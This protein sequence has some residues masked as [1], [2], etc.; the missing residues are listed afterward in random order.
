MS[1]KINYYDGVSIKGICK[2]RDHFYSISFLFMLKIILESHILVH[3][4]LNIITD[5]H[6]QI[7]SVVNIF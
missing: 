3:K 2:D 7:S 5:W 4:H 1:I 6:T